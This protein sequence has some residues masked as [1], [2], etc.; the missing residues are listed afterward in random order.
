MKKTTKKNRKSYKRRRKSLKE[1]ENS[2]SGEGKIKVYEFL[3]KQEFSREEQLIIE[4]GKFEVLEG[5]KNLGKKCEKCND[6]PELLYKPKAEL[7][8]LKHSLDLIFQDIRILTEIETEKKNY[9]KKFSKNLE[10]N[11]LK[12]NDMMELVQYSILQNQE[13]YTSNLETVNFLF[14]KIFE[15]TKNLYSAIL[16]KLKKTTEKNDH[17]FNLISLDLNK[18]KKDLKVIEEDISDNFSLI[19]LNMEMIPFQ[20][21]MANY[22]LKIQ[23]T[24]E[25]VVRSKQEILKVE[26]FNYE[27]CEGRNKED[28]CSLIEENLEK[29]TDYLIDEREVNFEFD[30][31]EKKKIARKIEIEIQRKKVKL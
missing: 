12:V 4:S 22:E 7:Y 27:F 23:T 21:I 2:L 24:M 9:L 30:F 28:L 18:L 29:V 19:V 17:I 16:Q 5:E 13:N 11:E 20:D 6:K 3:G 15:T 10:D 8:C 14:N 25:E 31:E 1:N 26:G